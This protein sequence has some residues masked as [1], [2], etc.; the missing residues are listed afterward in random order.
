MAS[1]NSEEI[2]T[3]LRELGPVVQQYADVLDKELSPYR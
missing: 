1:K 2:K 3:W